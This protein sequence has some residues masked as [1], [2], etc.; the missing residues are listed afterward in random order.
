MRLAVL[1]VGMASVVGCVAQSGEGESDLGA[2]KGDAEGTGLNERR[3]CGD[4]NWDEQQEQCDD[5]DPSNGPSREC[6]SDCRFTNPCMAE[7]ADERHPG[8]WA[9]CFASD[10]GIENWFAPLSCRERCRSRCGDDDFPCFNTC[11]NQCPQPG[12]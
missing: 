4:G 8:G 10:C 12:I 11:N 9:S 7:C 3:A 5:G 2:G 1:L 6:G